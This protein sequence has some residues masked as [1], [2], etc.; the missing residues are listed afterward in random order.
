MKTIGK[1]SGG[2]GLLVLITSPFTLLLTSGSW[3]A[4]GIKAG[5]GAV[6]ILFWLL[7]RPPRA[8]AA[9]KGLTGSSARAGFFYSSSALM[10]VVLFGALVAANFI[11]AKRGTTWD[12]TTRQIHSLAP[13]TTQALKALKAPVK[14]LAF[15]PGTHAARDE[16]EPILKKYADA[17][18]KFTFEFKD[19]F[20]SPDLVAK[21]Q[22]R[23]GQLP[24]VLTQGTGTEETHT[25]LN[26]DSL[27]EEALTRGI[28]LQGQPRA[29]RLRA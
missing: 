27:N 9:A 13:Q 19:P 11:A 5:A 4:A 12:L 26:S 18:D 3:L 25:N 16:F 17:S 23:Q 22:L 14:V 10:I 6:L 15:L 2:L 28:P 7:T 1:I 24:I 29:R 8:E 21:Y 20:K